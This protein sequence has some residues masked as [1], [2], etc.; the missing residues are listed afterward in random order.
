MWL[1]VASADACG[2][3]SAFFGGGSIVIP[4]AGPRRPLLTGPLPPAQC[5][6]VALAPFEVPVLESPHDFIAFRSRAGVRR[7]V[8]V[9]EPTPESGYE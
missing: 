1:A 9:G 8:L 4:T 7:S 2:I 3:Y 5:S 6:F